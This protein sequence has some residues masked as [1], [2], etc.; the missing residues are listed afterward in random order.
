MNPARSCPR[1]RQRG[2]GLVELLLACAL[3][4][5]LGAATLALAAQQIE[6]QQRLQRE[7]RLEQEL[8]AAADLIVRDL[9]R[10][11]HRGDAAEAAA[12]AS[13]GRDSPTN[14]YAGLALGS[15]GASR[16]VGHAYSRDL[17]EDGM[18]AGNERFGVQWQPA[19]GTLEWRLSGSAL[20]PGPRDAWQ[21]LVD[22]AR[23]QV[24]DLTIRIDE[25]RQALLDWCPHAGA[26]SS[27][28]GCP[29]ERISRQV[30]LR[31][32]AQDRQDAR[33]QRTIEVRARLRN[34]EVRGACP[35]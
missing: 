19:D 31:L 15:D 24:T 18:V 23:V 29:P 3:A 1:Q 7:I 20:T 10:A 25:E 16:A 11:G 26:C 22:P 8:R 30:W 35:T 14:P 32:Q 4:I 33:L 9:R 13:L 28:N 17:V 6:A 2:L 27:Q 5:G 12:R 34:D 21:S